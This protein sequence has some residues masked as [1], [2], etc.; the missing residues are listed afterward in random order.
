MCPASSEKYDGTAHRPPARSP[1]LTM[2]GP[3]RNLTHPSSWRACPFANCLPS[4]S[5]YRGCPC[6]VEAECETARRAARRR[7]R[8]IPQIYP[9]M[10]PLQVARVRPSRELATWCVLV[11]HKPGFQVAV[12]QDSSIIS[13]PFGSRRAVQCAAADVRRAIASF[14]GVQHGSSG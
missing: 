3:N 5:F 12:V 10:P 8:R 2:A 1:A 13:S 7:R 9:R 6:A 11:V 14:V 4:P